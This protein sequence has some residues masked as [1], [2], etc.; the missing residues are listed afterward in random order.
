[1]V[2]RN[3]ISASAVMVIKYR[4]MD[5]IYLDINADYIAAPNLGDNLGSI[6]QMLGNNIHV[7]FVSDRCVSREQS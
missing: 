5:D 3:L 1:M 7:G 6:M 2:N 4:I